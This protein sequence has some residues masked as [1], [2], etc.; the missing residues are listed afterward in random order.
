MKRKIDPPKMTKFEGNII[1][2][3]KKK[4]FDPPNNNNKFEGNIIG[5]KR[6]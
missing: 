6:K 1:G 2:M 5:M 3:K 4:S